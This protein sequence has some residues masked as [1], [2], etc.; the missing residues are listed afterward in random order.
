M[1]KTCHITSLPAKKSHIDCLV[2]EPGP[3]PVLAGVL[4]V[5]ARRPPISKGGRGVQIILKK[6]CHREN[7]GFEGKFV[8]IW[9]KTKQTDSLGLSDRRRLACHLSLQE[10]SMEHMQNCKKWFELKT[11]LSKNC[12]ID[13]FHSE[14]RPNVCGTQGA[15]EAEHPLV[16]WP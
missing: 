12:T 10:I 8:W 15:A 14:G 7:W 2:C 6:F 5:R 4:C 9:T 1:E 3:G 16:H 11:R 13:K